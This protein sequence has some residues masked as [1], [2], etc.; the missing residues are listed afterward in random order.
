MK[1]LLDRL[2][3]SP[4][5]R[6]IRKF[7]EDDGA[8][9]AVIIAWNLLLTIFPIV[10]ALTA[11]AGVVLSRIG[12]GSSQVSDLVLKLFPHDPAAQA[13]MQSAL[14]G[15]QQ[16]T[17]IFAIVALV[18]F[19]W[20]ASSLFGAMEQAFDTA[21][22]CPRRG[23]LPQKLMALL[24]MIAFSVLVIAAVGSSTLVPLLDRLPPPL[25]VDAAHVAGATQLGA[26]LAAGFLLFL[27]LYG[28]V[29]NRRLRLRHIWP[30]ALFACLALDILSQLFPLYLRLNQGLNQ[31]GQTFALLFVLLAFF[32]FL[33]LITMLGVEVNAVW[34]EARE[35]RVSRMSVAPTE[36][37]VRRSLPKRVG[38]VIVAAGVGVAAALRQAPG[39][40]RAEP[41][42]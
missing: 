7:G 21:L 32:Y 13:Q 36:Q 17:G 31:Y 39:P 30:G 14:A 20:T 40:T 8:N 2:F 27:I 10:L 29:P 22:G 35:G 11:I 1:R 34:I 28:G 37:P 24:M 25:H 26:G 42:K 15:V 33:G 16:R 5:G 18:G 38:L 6:V 23:F 4:P 12:A 3:A 19:L 9:W 41:R